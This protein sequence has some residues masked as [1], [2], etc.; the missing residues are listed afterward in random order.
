MS[1]TRLTAPGMSCEASRH[2][3]EG[4]LTVPGVRSVAVHLATEG[5]DV[6]Q[7]QDMTPER[8]VGAVEDS[9]YTVTEVNK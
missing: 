5:V 8:M 9:G 2:A 7:T 6:T 3:V 1:H 4:A